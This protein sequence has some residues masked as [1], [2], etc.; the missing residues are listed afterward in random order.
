MMPILLRTCFIEAAI[1]SFRFITCLLL[2]VPFIS[3]GFSAYFRFTAAFAG[4]GFEAYLCTAAALV[5]SGFEAYLCL[6]AVLG[7]NEKNPLWLGVDML[8]LLPDF[9][10]QN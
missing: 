8:N 7:A 2:E 1:A 9:T 6:T 10:S 4:S 3:S 5:G